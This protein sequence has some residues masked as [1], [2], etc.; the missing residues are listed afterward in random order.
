MFSSLQ[1][2][3]FCLRLRVKRLY[4]NGSWLNRPVESR[5]F[6]ITANFGLYR[7]ITH[8]WRWNLDNFHVLNIT[9]RFWWIHLPS[10][11]ELRSL[12]WEILL[13][14]WIWRLVARPATSPAVILPETS[15][16][17]LVLIQL[18]QLKKR[19]DSLNGVLFVKY[20]F[21]FD[22][23]LLNCSVLNFKRE[24]RVFIRVWGG[25]RNSLGG[26][27]ERQPEKVW[28]PLY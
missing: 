23:Y 16:R 25:A 28:E 12:V 21:V 2:F 4:V 13:D 27:R 1:F 8:E 5:S 9:F 17:F 24:A 14:N 11:I 3:W 18:K 26:Q 6:L 15:Y 22:L 19:I 7:N 20:T 10:F